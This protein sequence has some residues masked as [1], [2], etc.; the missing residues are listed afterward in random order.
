M[1]GSHCGDVLQSGGGSPRYCLHLQHR[2]ATQQRQGYHILLTSRVIYLELCL[3]VACLVCSSTLKTEAAYS[4]EMS[5]NFCHT[6]WH[7]IP[8]NSVW[9][10]C[11][12]SKCSDQLVFCRTNN[13]SAMLHTAYIRSDGNMTN[14][15]V[16]L[17]T[18]YFQLPFYQVQTA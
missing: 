13:E 10:Q 7:Q 3:L 11:H 2:R 15:F 4:S 12:N 1:R 16:M 9:H 17:H 6:M 14:G 8:E 18:Y 5:E